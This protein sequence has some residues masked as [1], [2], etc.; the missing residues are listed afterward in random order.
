MPVFSRLDDG[1]RRS[2]ES[3]EAKF[4]ELAFKYPNLRS[5]IAICPD[6]E[7]L[8]LV[9]CIASDASISRW[10]VYSNRPEHVVQFLIDHDK[11]GQTSFRGFLATC[12]LGC[13]IPGGETSVSCSP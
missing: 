8:Y 10:H 7:S 12:S 2:L 9:K 3:L 5:E 6:R 13:G 4:R 11:P 1:A